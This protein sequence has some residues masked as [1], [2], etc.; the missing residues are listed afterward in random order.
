MD[1]PNTVEEQLFRVV[2]HDGNRQI[3]HRRNHECV[4]VIIRQR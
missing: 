3:D 1:R 4:P 2:T